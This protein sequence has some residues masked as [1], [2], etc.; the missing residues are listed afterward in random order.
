[1]WRRRVSAATASTRELP[2]QI[3]GAATGTRLR[4]FLEL[5]R[6]DSWRGDWWDSSFRTNPAPYSGRSSVTV[7]ASDVNNVVVRLKPHA[8]FSGRIIVESDPA[9]PNDKP[10]ARIP[11]RLDPAGGEGSL[12]MPQSSFQQDGPADSFTIPGVQP[13]QYLLRVSGYAS[14]TA[15][16]ITWKGREYLD[17]P[18]DTTAAEDF[19]GIYRHGDQC[20]AR[21]RRLRSR[22]D[23]R[24]HRICD[25]RC[26]SRRSAPCGAT[27]D[28]IPRA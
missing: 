17:A 7:G 1:V 8:V 9:K 21:T 4:V 24:P 27:Q 6:S 16:S 12:G 19:S 22:I 26:V 14:W 25:G 18:F 2:R 5:H 20:R 10:P 3:P 13:G 15:K 28:S 11:V 23:G